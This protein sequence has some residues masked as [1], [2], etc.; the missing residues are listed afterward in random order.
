LFYSYSIHPLSDLA[1][2]MVLGDVLILWCSFGI[3]AHF[4]SCFH[5]VAI[6]TILDTYFMFQGSHHLTFLTLP[7]N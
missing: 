2:L 7:F 6:G 3:V 5:T 4:W 1:C